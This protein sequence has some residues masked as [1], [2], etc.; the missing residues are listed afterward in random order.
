MHKKII[1][2]VFSDSFEVLRRAQS[3][4]FLSQKLFMEACVNSYF[5]V[6]FLPSFVEHI[7]RIIHFAELRT[8][9]ARVNGMK[10]IIL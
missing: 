9:D 6:P 7:F 4:S 2:K 8:P 5:Q 1:Q 3:Y 10:P